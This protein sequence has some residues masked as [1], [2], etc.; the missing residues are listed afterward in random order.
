MYPLRSNKRSH[1]V[2]VLAPHHKALMHPEPQVH[3]YAHGNPQ[4]TIK[5]S[6]RAHASTAGGALGPSF[7]AVSAGLDS[8]I[9]PLAGAA[10]GAIYDQRNVEGAQ[11][12]LMLNGRAPEENPTARP[13][14]AD[15][16][17]HL[18][19]YIKSLPTGEYLTLR[20]VIT[21]PKIMC[22]GSCAVLRT[23]CLHTCSCVVCDLLARCAALHEPRR[24]L[25]RSMWLGDE[26]HWADG[27]ERTALHAARC[28]EH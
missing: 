17:A 12:C 1:Q 13:I 11:S 9:A 22:G 7:L 14:L 21:D 19:T 15:I 25:D 20:Q 8:L 10:R 27:A 4:H 26:A 5:V 24:P 28:R 18:A 3:T 2:E 23:A 16:H 6:R